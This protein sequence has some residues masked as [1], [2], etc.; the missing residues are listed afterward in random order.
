M[1]PVEP[2][3]PTW[4][5]PAAPTPVEPPATS[6][7]RFVAGGAAAWLAGAA[8]LRLGVLLPE[9]GGDVTAAEVTAAAVAAVGWFTRNQRRDGRWLYRHRKRDGADLGDYNEV[10]HA[11]VSWSLMQAATVLGSASGAAPLSPPAPDTARDAAAGAERGVDRAL[12]RLLRR[13]GWAVF[14]ASGNRA[15]VGANAL[16]I[17]ALVERRR[18]TGARD[19][20][21]ELGELGRFLLAVAQPDGAV[22]A[23]YDLAR[24]RPNVG[25]WSPYFTGEVFWA[26]ARLAS[27]FPDGPWREPAL[28][29]GRYIGER[30]DAR[31]GN[32]IP[33][34]DHWACYGLAELEAAGDGREVDPDGSLAAKLGALV[35]VQVRFDAQRTNRLPSLATRGPQGS[36]SF[37][38]TKGEALGSLWAAAALRGGEGDWADLLAERT[39]R[40]AA[41]LVQR[42]VGAADAAGLP[43]GGGAEGA[44]FRNGITQMDD[45]QHALS[46]LLL[47]LPVLA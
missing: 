35:G 15:G 26:L 44:W 30:R 9:Q 22:P 5:E 6:R 39:R 43:N 23:S 13:D 46:A 4:G 21:G 38:G 47:T 28:A 31:E 10:R 17:A 20:D 16:L 24:D 19:R 18:R 27:E 42:Q 37:L 7:R 14:G 40:A 3:A 32:R 34:A 29:I 8:G 33:I 2:A 25:E 12:D 36:A 11:G 41:L 1:D 45:Q